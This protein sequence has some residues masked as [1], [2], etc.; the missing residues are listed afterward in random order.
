M[1]NCAMAKRVAPVVVLAGTAAIIA[2]PFLFGNPYLNRWGGSDFQSHVVQVTQGWGIPLY[3][4]GDWFLRCLW[5]PIHAVISAEEFYLVVCMLSLPAACY[6]IYRFAKLGG[7]GWATVPVVLFGCY[8]V[9]E[10]LTDA[11]MPDFIAMYV[12]GMGYL[13]ALYKWLKGGGPGTLLLSGLLLLAACMSH[14]KSGGELFLGSVMLLVILLVTRYQGKALTALVVAIV[15][16]GVAVVLYL[17]VPSGESLVA[18]EVSYIAGDRTVPTLSGPLTVRTFM[19]WQFNPATATLV[20]V[21]VTMMVSVKEQIKDWL[22]LAMV[23]CMVAVL[24]VGGFT[25]ITRHPDRL[26]LDLSIFL[27]IGLAM[28]YGVV[29]EGL[30]R[31]RRTAYTMV[32]VVGLAVSGLVAIT[33]YEGV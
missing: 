6:M 21:S 19:S 28:M 7:A 2:Y 30:P 33:R 3:Y 13:I 11:I 24:A 16:V 29:S 26:G 27:C 4:W 17:K 10:Y 8:G 22:P 25:G 23:G 12:L 14:Y 32:M 1:P 18:G 5:W 20:A 31:I 15:V 9:F